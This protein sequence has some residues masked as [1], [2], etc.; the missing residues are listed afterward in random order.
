M[1]F[2]AMDQAAAVLLVG[3]ALRTAPALRNWKD[4]NF[5]AINHR[6]VADG[7]QRVPSG[8]EDAARAADRRP[9]LADILRVRSGV[10]AA[11]ARRP[12]RS[13]GLSSKRRSAPDGP[14]AMRL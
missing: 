3:S 4:H 14:T 13:S 11:Q 7:Q 8:Q 10:G 6:M 5:H 9:I 1:L 12:S 2:A